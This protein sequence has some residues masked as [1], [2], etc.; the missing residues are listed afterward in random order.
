MVML[1]TPDADIILCG[2]DYVSAIIKTTDF[3][4]PR[5]PVA[6]LFNPTDAYF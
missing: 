1:Q 2:G 6:G 5:Y 4:L 3:M